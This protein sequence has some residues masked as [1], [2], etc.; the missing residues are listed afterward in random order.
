MKN[1]SIL[2]L[3]IGSSL[4]LS[5]TTFAM[6]SL[7]SVSDIKESTTQD[8]EIIFEGKESKLTPGVKVKR[9]AHLNLDSINETINQDPTEDFEVIFEGENQQTTAG[10]K[11]KRIAHLAVDIT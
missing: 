10:I 8:F 11:V 5:G 9:I 7:S 1:K 6:D 4:G 2:A 3:A